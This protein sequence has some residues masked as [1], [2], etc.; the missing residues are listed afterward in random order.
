MKILEVFVINTNAKKTPENHKYKFFFFLQNKSM[1]NKTIR[2]KKI[3]QLS[4]Y[5]YVEHDQKFISDITTTNKTSAHNIYLY[6]LFEN[7]KSKTT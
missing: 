3:A 5:K 7:A 2:E 1:K 4:P 6:L